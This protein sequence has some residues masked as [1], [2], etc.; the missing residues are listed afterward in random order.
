MAPR[1]GI[2]AAD[3][4][5]A[6]EAAQWQAV[7]AEPSRAATRPRPVPGMQRVPVREVLQA[8]RFGCF[9]LHASLLPRWPE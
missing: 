7:R 4:D 2:I 1:K 8:P 3:A 5:L 9:N 6:D